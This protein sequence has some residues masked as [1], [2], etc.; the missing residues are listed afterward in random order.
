MELPGQVIDKTIRTTDRLWNYL[1]RT[2]ESMA[3][4]YLGLELMRL[5]KITDVRLLGFMREGLQAYDPRG[6]RVVSY[7]S[8]KHQEMFD[9]CL[10]SFHLSK[11]PK[12]AMVQL[13]EIRFFVF[14]S[15]DVRAFAG[16]NGF[17]LP[18][19]RAKLTTESEPP[20]E[21]KTENP[22]QK[23]FRQRLAC[24]KIAKQLWMNDPTIMVSRMV[25]R[26]EIVGASGGRSYSIR[27]GWVRDLRP[28]RTDGR[29]TK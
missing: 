4:F 10:F 15:E 23:I 7:E 1:T 17:I 5:W 27:Y 29:W 16:T 18:P 24:R 13:K 20:N 19:E 22:T 25:E 28:P 26:P 14:Q 6:R 21:V 11:N 12:E 3:S 9:Y 2:G 8:P